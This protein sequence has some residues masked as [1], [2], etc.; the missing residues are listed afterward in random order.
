M[1]VIPDFMESLR[2][3]AEVH[4]KK[5]DDYA[6]G[7][8]PF[9]NFDVQEYIGNL[10]HNIRDKVFAIMIAVKIARLAT[11]LNKKGEEPNNESIEDSFIDAANYIL[12]WKADYVRRKKLKS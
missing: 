6:S 7:D 10:F 9:S 1:P 4:K 8:N 3:M 2:V 11:L 5:N 12:I